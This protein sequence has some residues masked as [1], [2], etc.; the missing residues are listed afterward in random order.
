MHCV[1]YPY[2]CS[3][4]ATGGD[5]SGTHKISFPRVFFSKSVRGHTNSG[6]CVIFF[7]RKEG[8]AIAYP[9]CRS[10]LIAPYV[11]QVPTL[12]TLV[13]FHAAYFLCFKGGIALRSAGPCCQRARPRVC[14]FSS[15]NCDHPSLNS[16]LRRMV[17]L[18]A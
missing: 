9:C 6:F 1:Q 8:V 4:A 18:I 16:N 12:A 17:A 7:K 13:D 14:R 10:P 2:A 5:Q 11:L 3:R 15:G